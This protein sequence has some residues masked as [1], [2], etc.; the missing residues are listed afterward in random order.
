MMTI[1]LAFCS[2]I[3]AATGAISPAFA[4]SDMEIQERALRAREI[5]R[6]GGDMDHQGHEGMV[7]EN[8]KSPYRGVFYGYL[9]CDQ[10]DCSGIKMT[11]SLNAGGR[12]LLVIQPARVLNRETFEKGEYIWDEG[13]RLLTLKPRNNGPERRLSIKDSSRL[14]YLDKDGKSASGDQS[15]YI[16]DRS[17]TADNRDVHIH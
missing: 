3:L 17:D 16:L 4:E 5:Q 15:R 11:L 9:P 7:K 2:F 6:N 12:Y 8:P 10:Q 14:L 1:R 13:E